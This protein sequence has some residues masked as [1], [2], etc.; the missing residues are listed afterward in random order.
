MHFKVC[1]NPTQARPCHPPV[2]IHRCCSQCCA[3]NLKRS[4][5]RLEKKVRA[6]GSLLLQPS[7]AP[8]AQQ[9]GKCFCF[10][11]TRVLAAL[12]HGCRRQG[13]T[14]YTTVVLRLPDK[15]VPDE[16]SVACGQCHDSFNMIRRRVRCIGQSASMHT[17]L[18]APAPL[19]TVWRDLLRKLHQERTVRHTRPVSELYVLTAN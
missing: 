4:K 1:D 9:N 3:I 16:N 12:R 8:S 10:S 5:S 13:Y 2:G 18:I 7:P 19:S 6:Y 11:S 15:W 17:D 14:K